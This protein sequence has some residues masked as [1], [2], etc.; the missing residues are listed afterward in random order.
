MRIE[1]AKPCQYEELQKFLEEV[2]GHSAGAFKEGWLEVWQKE[3]TEFDNSLLI[4]EENRIVAFLRV[5][6]I[7]L[8]QNGVT[9]ESGGIGSVSTLYSHRGKGYM[10]KLLEESFRLMDSKKMPISILWGDR[11]RYGFF[12]YENCGT[13]VELSIKSRGLNK[14]GIKSVETERFFYEEPAL[15]EM[16]RTFNSNNYK[17]ERNKKEFID[18]S[19]R[20]GSAT[21]YAFHNQEFAYLIL[22]STESSGAGNI[23]EFGG[24]PELL[25]GILKY[26]SERFSLSAFTLPFPSL[27]EVPKNLLDISSAWNIKHTF[28]MLKIIDLKETLNLFIRQTDACFPDGEEITFTIK[29]RE[30]VTVSKTDGI[31]SVKEG[32]GKNE[33]FLNENDMVRLLF[34]STFWAPSNINSKVFN[35]LRSFL[36][37]KIF[38]WPTDYI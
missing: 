23:L 7:T 33:I 9:I 31:V 12:G 4:S 3:N 29:G 5:F 37:F 24:N 11:H 10:S 15:N 14:F 19:S 21:Y 38:V 30:S 1:R 32:K 8:N 26:L 17:R 25:L 20:R 27:N 35:L 22:P 28:L 13:C 6:P 34:G 36:P 18:I 16:I 2:Y